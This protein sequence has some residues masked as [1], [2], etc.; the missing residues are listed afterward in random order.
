MDYL[1]TQF[2]SIKAGSDGGIFDALGIDVTM[3]M[4]QGIAFLILVWLLRKFVYPIL[5]K[6][7]DDRQMKI[8]ESIHAAG[9]AKEKA[10]EAQAEVAKLLT[11]ARK[12]AKDIVATAKEEATASLNASDDKAISRAKKIVENAHEQIEKDVIA[13]KKALHNETIDLVALATEAVLGKTMTVAI[14]KQV[15]GAAIKEVE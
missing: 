1:V 12:D 4:L 5:I 3:L 9:S 8:E 6:S 13:A 7:V 14:D 10:E 2:A 15:V 11:Q